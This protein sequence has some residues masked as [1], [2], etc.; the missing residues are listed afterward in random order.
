MNVKIK[1]ILLSPIW[2]W[3]LFRIARYSRKYYKGKR[4]DAAQLRND[5]ILKKALKYLKMYKINL[6]VTGYENLG[7]SGPALLI[8]NHCDEADGF[9]IMAALKKQTEE[10]DINNKI[11]TFLAKAELK[12]SFKSRN[13]LRL[14]DSFF[15]ERDKPREALKTL[16]EFGE[17][18]KNNK[19]Y[20]VIFPEGTR[21]LD[22]NI[23]EFKA[24]AFKIA[25]KEFLT[26]IPVTIKNSFES[27]KTS[28]SNW[29]EIEVIFHNPIKPLTFTSQTNES[30]A[31]RVK[32]I[33][34][35][36]L[37]KSKIKNV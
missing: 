5:F 34:S 21:S 32:N 16:N 35:N 36:E 1:K 14:I 28:R 9:F 2:A 23:Q 33:I 6:K 17:F 11:P 31:L 8:P 20:G 25:K 12:K 10:K 18:I 13:V 24:G 15:I 29:L 22:G 27:S 26:I 4:N 37:N 30:I 3:R 7:K 19:T